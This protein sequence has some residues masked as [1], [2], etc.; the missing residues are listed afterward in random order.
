[1]CVRRSV[2]V[3]VCVSLSSVW[4]GVFTLVAKR[5]TEPWQALTVASNMMAWSITMDTLGAGQATAMTVMPRGADWNE[6]IDQLEGCGH[7]SDQSQRESLKRR[8]QEAKEKATSAAGGA[9]VARCADA[10]AVLWRAGAS[11]LTGTH[12]GAVCTP[13]ALLTHA[14]TVHS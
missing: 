1:M 5:A 14:V 6:K 3:W 4:V 12:H 8:W 9:P 10:R 11:V 2:C 7:Q 13:V